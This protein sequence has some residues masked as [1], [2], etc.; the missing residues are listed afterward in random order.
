[1]I[2]EA[3]H[4]DGAPHQTARQRVVEIERADFHT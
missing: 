1:M 2:D 4:G 3:E